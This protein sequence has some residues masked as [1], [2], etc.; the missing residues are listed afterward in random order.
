[1]GRHNKF[2]EEHGCLAML[3]IAVIIVIVIVFAYY[4][5]RHGLPVLGPWIIKK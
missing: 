3:I 5:V 1:M 4:W 2:L